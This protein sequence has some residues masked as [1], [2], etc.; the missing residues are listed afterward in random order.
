MSWMLNVPDV[1]LSKHSLPHPQ[2]TIPRVVSYL[3]N[4]SLVVK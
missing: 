3:M 1:L 4:E 2:G